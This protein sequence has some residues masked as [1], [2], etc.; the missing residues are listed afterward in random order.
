MTP[1]QIC[2]PLFLCL[3][4]NSQ[5]ALTSVLRVSLPLL[6]FD[7]TKLAFPSKLGNLTKPDLTKR[8]SPVVKYDT[9]QKTNQLIFEF[10][11]SE[12]QRPKWA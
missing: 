10:D 5:M 2:A 7:R 3:K 6:Q 11:Y 9:Y 1:A 4:T 8:Y 12:G